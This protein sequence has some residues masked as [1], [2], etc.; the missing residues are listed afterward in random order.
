MA[1][2]RAVEAELGAEVDGEQLE[3]AQRGAEQTLDERIG[4]ID[5]YGHGELLGGGR[6][7]AA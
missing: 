1:L 7:H 4:A 6:C 2:E 3:R 5:G